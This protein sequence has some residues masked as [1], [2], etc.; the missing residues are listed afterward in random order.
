MATKWAE[1][2]RKRVVEALGGSLLGSDTGYSDDNNVWR[3]ISAQSK[4][5]K[6]VREL[7]PL[8]HQEMLRV[9][10]YLYGANPL[11]KWLV[12]M[13]VGLCI[14]QELGYTISIDEGKASTAGL[15]DPK[16]LIPKIRK[17]LDKF[18]Y[19]PAHRLGQAAPKWAKTYLVTGHLV[20]PISGIN[21]VDGIPRLDLIDAAQIVAVDPIEG[22]SIV[23][24]RVRYKSQVTSGTEEGIDILQA[25]DDGLLVPEAGAGGELPCLYFAHSEIINSMRGVSILMAVADWLDGLDQFTWAALDKAKLRNKVVW[26]LTMEGKTADQ[27]QVEANALMA[28]LQAPGGVYAGN[29]KTQLEAK[30]ANLGAADTVE[31][32]RMILTHILGSQGFPQSWYSEGGSTNRSTA[33]EQTDVAYKSLLAMQTELGGI[34]QT[35]LHMA[36]DMAQAKQPSAFP[37]RS[38]SPW[39]TIAPALPTISERDVSRLA[40]SLGQAV[41]AL[42]EGVDGEL[43]SRKTAQGAT[44]QILGKVTG[45]VYEVDEEQARIDAEAEER[46]LKDQEK[47][48]QLARAMQDKALQAPPGAPGAPEQ[49]NPPEPDATPTSRAM[50][51]GRGY[52]RTDPV[53]VNLGGVHV[54][55]PGSHVEVKPQVSAPAVHVHPAAAPTPDVH[56]VVEAAVVPPAPVAPVFV[57]VAAPPA[58]AAPQVTIQNDVH[59]PP[60]APLHVERDGRGNITDIVPKE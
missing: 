22:S 39:L 41:A 17:V 23:P 2:L 42:L 56:V 52:Y 24:G 19:H 47:A 53:T 28:K 9:A 49:A 59:V 58:P 16:E 11:A 18:W 32:G 20:V 5:G 13:P 48:N 1:R 8:A 21:E 6:L 7:T 15:A 51:G 38:E 46:A 30:S 44:L 29:D 10:L 37:L 4:D 43:I 57:S 40:A 50:E 55:T 34:F 60:P 33:A 3:P 25:N 35:F 45:G 26:L 36:Y 14:G 12:N 31:L 54:Q 27:L